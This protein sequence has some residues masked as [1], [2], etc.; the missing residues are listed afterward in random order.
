MMQSSM[1][2]RLAGGVALSMLSV[3]PLH[4]NAADSTALATQKDRISYGMGVDIA[5]NLK[6]Q[7][8]DVDLKLLTRGMEDGLLGKETLLPEKELRQLMTVFQA[9]VRRK[10]M[11]NA[12]VAS[13]EN[14]KKGDAFLVFR[15][16]LV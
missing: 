12:K 8:V 14:K 4:S 3:W 11:E 2:K 6:K 16:A 1:V 9:D 15:P 5:R 10:M 7:G 13:E